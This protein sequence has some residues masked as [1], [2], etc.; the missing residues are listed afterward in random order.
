[1]LAKSTMVLGK[2]C[3]ILACTA[4][5][6][7]SW[8]G[9][10]NRAWIRDDSLL[11]FAYNI[12][13]HFTTRLNK[14]DSALHTQAVYHALENLENGE[15]VEWYNDR[16]DSQGKARIV[17]TWQGS[18]NICRR[19]FSWVK[20]GDNARNFEDTACYNVDTKTWRFVD[21]Y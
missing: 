21:K 15:L 18:G 19:V 1:M 7:Q 9:P 5:H 20:F 14:E 11:G 16:S 10:T 17:Y 3:L 6:A 12:S 2:L 13:K 8:N 4:S